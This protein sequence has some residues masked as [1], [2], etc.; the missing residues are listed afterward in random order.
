MS[1]R[2][3]VYNGKMNS[4]ENYGKLDLDV[5]IEV[6]G[7]S[8]VVVYV[9][10]ENGITREAT[11]EINGENNEALLFMHHGPYDKNNEE[12]TYNDEPSFIAKVGH[13][14]AYAYNNYTGQ[15]NRV[16]GSFAKISDEGIEM[17]ETMDFPTEQS[18]PRL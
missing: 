12:A 14:R 13:D 7:D 16:G 5:K 15:G 18:N 8:R 1:D 2:K 6:L 10:D 9:S 4:H 3:T 17:T 11:I